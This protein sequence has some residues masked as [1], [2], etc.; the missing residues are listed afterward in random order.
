MR[1]RGLFFSL[2]VLSIT[3]L[4]LAGL[5]VSGPLAGRRLAPGLGQMKVLLQATG[6]EVLQPSLELFAN[7]EQIEQQG[8]VTAHD[9]SPASGPKR[10][11]GEWH[12][13]LRRWA[14]EHHFGRGATDARVRT[15]DEE[16]F[17]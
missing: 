12:R 17:G 4:A 7:L 14:L 13:S 11:P 9:L 3:L 15:R 5:L 1:S 8:A 2:S 16:E 10:K 6:L